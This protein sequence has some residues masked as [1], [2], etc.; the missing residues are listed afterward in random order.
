MW[1]GETNQEYPMSS[2]GVGAGI[3]SAVWNHAEMKTVEPEMPRGCIAYFLF[4]PQAGF[5]V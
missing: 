3:A 1:R 4:G 2:F 5:A